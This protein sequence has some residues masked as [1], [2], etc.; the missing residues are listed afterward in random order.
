MSPP[1]NDAANPHEP[2]DSLRRSGRTNPWLVFLL[3]LAIYMLVGSFEPAPPAPGAKP[4]EATFFHPPYSYYPLIYA[5]KIALTVAAIAYVWPGHR[6]FPFRVSWLA[7][8]VGAAGFVVWIGLADAERFM[9]AHA[10][11]WLREWGQ[12][13][14]YNP[15]AEFAGR[16]A[17]AYGFLAIRLIGLALIVPLIEEF[18]LRGFV[19]R[20]VVANDWWTVPFGQVNRLAIIAG[21]LVPVLMHPAAEWLAA[22]V[23]FSG[24]TWLMLRTRNIWDCV[25]AHAVTNLL[26]GLYVLK[27]GDWGLL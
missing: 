27:T 24:I 12:R 6:Q 3:P 25:A 5:L 9:I 17:L 26:L 1:P 20:F 23:W 19:M 4:A 18:F 14:G 21:T 2:P 15:L 11:A 10:P 7:I 8:G 16:P 13:S 22:A